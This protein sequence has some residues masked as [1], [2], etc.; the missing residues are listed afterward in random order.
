MAE[1]KDYDGSVIIDVDIDSKD[2]DKGTVDVEKAIKSLEATMTKAVEQM[3]KSISETLAETLKNAG[4]VANSTGE[5]I[6]KTASNATKGVDEFTSHVE[7]AMEELEQ[8]MKE[9]PENF[10]DY[11]SEMPS[12]SDSDP[13]GNIISECISSASSVQ[14]ELNGAVRTNSS[15]MRNEMDEM[16][17]ATERSKV[18]FKDLLNVI[19]ECFTTHYPAA[20]NQMLQDLGGYAWNVINAFRNVG[21]VIGE[22]TSGIIE[23]FK[24]L[25]L[26]NPK[27]KKIA[28]A[29]LRIAK[30]F[31]KVGSAVSGAAA[32]LNIF[33]KNQKGADA[34]AKKLVGRFTRIFTMV[35]SR[36]IRKFVSAIFTGITD[37]IKELAKVDAKFNESI[38][39]IKSKFKQLSYTIMSTFAPLINTAAPIFSKITEYV[40]ALTDKVAQ[41]MAALAGQSTYQKANYNYTDYAKSLDDTTESTDNLADSTEKLNKQLAAFDELN[42]LSATSDEDTSKSLLDNNALNT[43]PI[44][45]EVPISFDISN[46]SQRIKEAFAKGDFGDLGAE[47]GKKL[48]EQIAK[49]DPTKI[50]STI[51]R[52]INSASSFA[53]EFLSSVHWGELTSK[54]VSNINTLI[55]EIDAEQLGHAFAKIIN[56]IFEI[57]FTI[58]TEFDW[59]GFGEKVAEFING[60]FDN[61]DREMIGKTI[62]DFIIG[63]LDMV[64]SF[65]DGLNGESIGEGIGEVVSQI[66]FIGIATRLAKIIWGILK[67]AWNILTGLWEG[68]GITGWWEEH[69][70]EPLGKAIGKCISDVKESWRKIKKWWNDNVI[71]GWKTI[72]NCISTYIVVPIK[73]KITQL[74]KDLEEGNWGQFFID[75]L[76]SPLVNVL[77][78]IL[79]TLKDFINNKIGSLNSVG[80][81][82]GDWHIGFDIPMIDFP[83]LT[84]PHLATGTVVPANYGEFAAILGDN[85]RETEVVSPLSTMKQAMIEAMAEVGLT[86]GNSDSGDIVINIDGR[87]IFRVTK[88]EAEKYKRTHGKPAF[89]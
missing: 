72:G 81:D 59:K 68:S 48:N 29:V 2:F 25:D 34:L 46:L 77:N 32:K 67:L 4:L 79:G 28:G 84:V 40:T 44:Y 42:V 10:Y 17:E 50:G 15:N 30:G 51:A 20:M 7:Q 45:T 6:E 61:A 75:L 16:T 82:F 41:L 21:S 80:V 56:T 63:F 26:F 22:K 38:S 3:S 66:D 62:N 71:A 60:V 23:Y 12:S 43:T 85:K 54:I 35:K 13:I 78:G 87:E 83:E 55:E 58:A 88:K 73:N 47:L 57:G 24:Q 14:A 11:R 52:V 36:I 53:I 86:G 18:T 70:A 76:L 31:K 19:K 89:G 37:G 74:K 1:K 5:T 65:I 8:L 33:N 39:T 69:L 27:L 49:I 64:L 9:H